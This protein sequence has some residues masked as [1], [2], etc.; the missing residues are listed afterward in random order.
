MNPLLVKNSQKC[1]RPGPSDL[2]RN[3][4]FN[5]LYISEVDMRN[6]LEADCEIFSMR[7]QEKFVG[8]WWN[9]FTSFNNRALLLPPSNRPDISN[10]V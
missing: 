9:M 6:A 3:N 10:K 1:A 5:E 4:K 7:T 8:K 2:F